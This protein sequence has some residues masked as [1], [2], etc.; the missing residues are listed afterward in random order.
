MVWF[1]WRTCR[2]SI[3]I[4]SCE[5]IDDTLCTYP[6]ADI[7]DA[8]VPLP[9]RERE[10]DRAGN[11]AG[12]D[13]FCRFGRRDAGGGSE[14]ASGAVGLDSRADALRFRDEVGCR[15]WAEAAG[16]DEEAEA[17]DSKAAW[18]ADALRVVLGDMS[19]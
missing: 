18:R 4:V 2:W 6:E 15:G 16:V 8:A 17:A 1:W 14:S 7:A 19:I 13:V 10:G 11:L 5:Y 12:S 9:F 3:D